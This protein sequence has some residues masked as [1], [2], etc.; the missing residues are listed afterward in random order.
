MTAP[1]LC[2][3]GCA[4]P[5]PIATHT[6]RRHG[7]VKGEPTR[8]LRGHYPRP[9][10]EAPPRPARGPL[11]PRQAQALAAAADGASLSTV[12][13]RLGITRERVSTL[14]SDAYRRLDVT[15]LPRAE[16]RAEA[17][18]V[19][20]RRGLIPNQPPEVTQQLTP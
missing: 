14:L 15:W 18:R 5:T 13:A 17:V 7:H 16:R 3:C 1:T 6:D 11:T 8:F 19:A 12:A 9:S 2:A 20:R 4:Q 10:R